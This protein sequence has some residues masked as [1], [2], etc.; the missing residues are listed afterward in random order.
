MIITISGPHG[1]GKSTYAVKLAKTL[2]LRHVSAGL[3]FRRLAKQRELSLEEFGILAAKDPTIDRIVDDE[4]LREAQEGNLVID[5]Q[6]VGWVLKEVADLR[7]FLTAPEDV[8]LR[9]IA[10]RDRMGFEEARKQ[11]LQREMIQNE[12][13]KTHYGLKVQ[14]RSIY[15][16]VLDTSFLSLEET[17]K[18]LLTIARAV[19]NKVQPKA[20]KA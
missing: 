7:V 1:T 14:D 13:Y 5:G 11:T 2:G 16:V 20:T 9:R 12:R 4:T 8:R 15:H 10:Q 18:V 6:L 19:V 3:L 17:E